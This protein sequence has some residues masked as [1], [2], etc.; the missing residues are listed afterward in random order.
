[1][2][3]LQPGASAFGSSRASTAG[4]TDNG[5]KGRGKGRGRGG[6]AASTIAK[7]GGIS[8]FGSA[9]SGFGNASGGGRGRGGVGR[10]TSMFGPIAQLQGVEVCFRFNQVT[11]CQR[12]KVT[13]RTC[14][15]GRRV[16]V[17]ACDWLDPNTGKHC[18]KDHA[19]HLGGH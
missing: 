12:Q 17:H 9:S 8:G 14:Q 18:L 6:P 13:P 16:F 15:E 5:P 2:D 4:L 1:M 3:T 7:V 10:G 11:G 19:K